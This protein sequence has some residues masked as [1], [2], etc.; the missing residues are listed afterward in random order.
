RA[1]KR[2]LRRFVP[3]LAGS[4][5]GERTFQ[6]GL[7]AMLRT[8]DWERN[9]PNL[10]RLWTVVAVLP[11][12]TVECEHSFSRHNVI[13]SWQ[14]TSLCD[15]R[16]SDLMGLSLAIRRRDT[17]NLL[18][19]G[20]EVRSRPTSASCTSSSRV[21]NS[22]SSSSSA[23][24]ASASSSSS[25][26]SSASSASA[27]SSSSTRLRRVTSSSSPKTTSPCSSS[28]PGSSTSRTSRCSTSATTSS[29]SNSSTSSYSVSSSRVSSSYSSTPKAGALSKPLVQLLWGERFRSGR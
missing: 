8:K 5:R 19:E 1:A 9:Y 25:S 22:S 11:L 18:K 15:A 21:N 6:H 26:S 16:L 20:N 13:K 28:T 29:S 12:S 14:R 2:E 24:S 23:S 4:P 7:A 3:V 17:K 27:S 10:V